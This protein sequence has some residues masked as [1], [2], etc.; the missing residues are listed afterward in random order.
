MRFAF[1]GCRKKVGS[2]GEY[3]FGTS[4]TA[5]NIWLD[6][7][8]FDEYGGGDIGEANPTAIFVGHVLTVRQSGDSLRA[9]LSGEWTA[10]FQRTYLQRE[11]EGTTRSTFI[12][13]VMVRTTIPLTGRYQVGAH[14]FSCT[15]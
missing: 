5:Q 3:E 9:N 6:I 8:N 11:R 7:F 14:L 4:T 13:S 2:T 12:F 1:E 10:P 15:E